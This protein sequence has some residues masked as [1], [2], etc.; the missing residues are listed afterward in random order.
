[1]RTTLD[2]PRELLDEVRRLLGA[3]SKADTVVLSLRELL[4]RK[5]IS[6]LKELWGAIPLEVDI[7]KSR[8]RNVRRAS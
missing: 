5:K 4:R 1:M 6:D 8:R 7:P 2:F 3:K